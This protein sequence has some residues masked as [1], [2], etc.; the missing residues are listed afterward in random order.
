M[1]KFLNKIMII[2]TKIIIHLF[3]AT[4]WGFTM[5]YNPYQNYEQFIHRNNYKYKG[6]RDT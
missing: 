3:R 5:Q 1:W 2:K 4:C 6:Q